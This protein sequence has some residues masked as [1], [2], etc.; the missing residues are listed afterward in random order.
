MRWL[1]DGL[2]ALVHS[3]ASMLVLDAGLAAQKKE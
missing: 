3:P 1:H 2:D